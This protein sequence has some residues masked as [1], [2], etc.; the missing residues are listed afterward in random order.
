MNFNN[1]AK[2]TFLYQAPEKVN[3]NTP[4]T[5]KV[6]GKNQAGKLITGE[7]KIIVARGI[8]NVSYANQIVFST[9]ITQARTI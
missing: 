5:I 1:F 2:A 4:I 7:Q 6:S 8:L 3:E 9:N